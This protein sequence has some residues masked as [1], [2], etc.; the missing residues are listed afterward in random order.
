MKLF[1]FK[2]KP[3]ATNN[4]SE[5]QVNNK[6]ES[7]KLKRESFTIQNNVH[8]R[9]QTFQCHI[10][11]KWLKVKGDLKV[12]IKNVHE[13]I[14]FKCDLC[15]RS[16]YDENKLTQHKVAAHKNKTN[17]KCKICNLNFSCNTSL[18]NHVKRVHKQIKKHVCAVCNKRFVTKSDLK[19]H[20]NVHLKLKEF[21]CHLCHQRFGYKSTLN[22]H[23]KKI[24]AN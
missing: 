3:V 4:K 24:H 11:T 20:A 21:E 22:R 2:L 7:Y 5:R 19:M 1:H 17:F 10:C 18:Y 9:R 14:C 12:H 16:Y 6:K 8:E 23:M 15:N 13:K